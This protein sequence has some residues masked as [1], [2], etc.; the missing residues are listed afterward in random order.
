MK[1]IKSGHILIILFRFL[2]SKRTETD[3]GK[4]GRHYISV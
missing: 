4:L 3:S 2:Y 1:L